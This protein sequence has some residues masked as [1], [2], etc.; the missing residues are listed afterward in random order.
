MEVRTG[1]EAA[2][3]ASLV[4]M[5]SDSLYKM[6][7]ESF[8]QVSASLPRT[9]W[10]GAVVDGVGNGGDIRARQEWLSGLKE[11]IKGMREIR[12]TVAIDIDQVFLDE[13]KKNLG[14][15]VVFGL[16]VDPRVLG[17]AAISYQGRYWDATLL[18]KVVSVWDKEK[19]LIKSMFG[20]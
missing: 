16:E 15:G 8:E 12:M 6:G 5:L 20:L 3:V 13:L 7:E 10:V 11:A 14:E 9:R 4:D 18:K 19:D 2:Q 17:G 1:D